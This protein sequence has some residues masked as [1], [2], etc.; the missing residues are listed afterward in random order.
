[1]V[2]LKLG[3]NFFQTIV[4]R[5]QNFVQICCRWWTDTTTCRRCRAKLSWSLCSILPSQTSSPISSRFHTLP[6]APTAPPWERQ[7]EGFSRTHWP[8]ETRVYLWNFKWKKTLSNRMIMTRKKLC[9]AKSYLW[10]VLNLSNSIY[11]G[12]WEKLF[13]PKKQNRF[14]ILALSYSHWSNFS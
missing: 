2:S 4:Y 11:F 3:L 6:R 1:M 10:V 12:K 7:S 8:F 9:F 5:D 14:I 13:S